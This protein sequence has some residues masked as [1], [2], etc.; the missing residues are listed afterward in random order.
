MLKFKNYI[1]VFIVLFFT[2]CGL[3]SM[4]S[5]FKTVDF[6]VTP[7]Q[8]EVHGGKISIE[9]EVTIPEKYFVKNASAEFRAMLSDGTDSDNK[10]YFKSI[11]IQGEKIS[12]DG[13]T[14]GY[15]TGGKFNY[16]SEIAYDK[17][18]FSYDLF[19]TAVATI[20]DKSKNLGAIKIADGV[21]ATATRVQ[22]N[23]T[24]RFSAHNYEKVTILEK[25]ATIF[26]TVNQSNVRYSQK[27]SD[28]IKALK[29]FA[30]LGYETKNVEISSYASPEGTLDVND[31]V[32]ENRSKSTF[33]YAKRL[34]RQIKIDGYNNN[35][36]YI[37]TSVGED[38]NGFNNLVQSSKMKDK[39]KVLNVVRNQKDPQKREEAIRDMSEI[40][41]AIEND[42]LPKLR[43]ATITIR[44]YQPKKTDEEI[45]NLA[46]S[47]PS[48]LD[49][50]ELLY[51]AHSNT[52]REQKIAIY[53][54]VSTLF[55]NDYRA[56]NNLASLALEVNDI[57][58]AK[59]YLD[60]ANSISSNQADVLENYGIIAA[61]ENDLQ[62]ASKFYSQSNAS[63][64]NK[65]I[66]NIKNGKYSAA[67]SQLNGNDFNSILAKVMNG[68]N[69]KFT[70][71]KSAH[72]NYLNAIICARKGNKVEALNY[73]KNAITDDELKAQAKEDIEFKAFQTD[74]E[75]LGIF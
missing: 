69:S 4:V 43:K 64:I 8:V 24:P 60:K 67:V 31:K 55:P 25:T 6:Q 39:S 3:E 49:I 57:S 63:D 65:G 34:M 2:S 47:D 38:W 26:F 30:K 62:K 16:K 10:H 53:N 36:I 51:A 22:D 5:K 40:Y 19:A 29:E 33:N 68:D 9:L 54:T 18:M 52:N 21:M 27:S 73:L 1:L 13:I 70:N 28:D 75:F 35:D 46:I 61:R 11:T 14:I 12:A 41:D 66:L 56:N 15:V 45:A 17:S 7:T 74:P 32:S 58:S 59:T 42:V 71:D 23:E 48:Q 37:N 72:G 44:S 20:N 50:K